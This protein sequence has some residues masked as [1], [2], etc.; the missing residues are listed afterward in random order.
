MLIWIYIVG[1]CV[2]W[3]LCC[4]CGYE[5]VRECKAEFTFGPGEIEI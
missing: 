4:E 3:C 2:G 5:G 1:C